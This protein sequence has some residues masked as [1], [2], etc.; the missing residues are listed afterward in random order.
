M[1]TIKVIEGISG[2][3]TDLM[4]RNLE[5][6]KK[7]QLTLTEAAMKRTA[8]SYG[9]KDWKA[10]LNMQREDFSI[11]KFREGSYAAA[12]RFST[13]EAQ[14][15]LAFGQLLR[16]GVQTTFN[17]IYQAVEVT[18]PAVV[19]EAGSNKRQEFY[20]PLERIGF[21]KKVAAQGSF[22]ETNFKGL[23]L[24]LVNSKY[25][26]IV[27]FEKELA[28]DD[29]TGQIVSRAGQMGENARIHEEA[30]V[31]ARLGNDT[32][33][34]LDGEALPVSATYGTVYSSAGIHTGG[35]GKNATAAGRLSATQIQNGWIL[36]KKMLDQSGRPMVVMPKIL[37]VSP[38][39]I[40]YAETLMNS[41][42]NP[43][44]ASTATGDDG[45]MFGNMTINPIKNLTAVVSTRFLHDY[46]ALLIDAGKGFVFQRR[47]P[48]EVVQEN[49]QSGPA[50]SQEV[51]RYKTRSRWEADFIDPKF[52]INLNTSFSST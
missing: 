28:D 31:W 52:I 23:D 37:A 45:K 19:R 51:F 39:D 48:Q 8:E 20:S 32:G 4:K 7:M 30:Y 18:Y 3:Q 9:I 6:S 25:G 33:A 11:K 34:S 35:Y 17:D 10:V 49:P 36:A 47:D 29:Q 21:P 42:L 46:A 43:S 24:E 2:D 41:E 15:E 27:A 14:A 26:M 22:P 16:A 50:F 1:K 38:Q 12:Q 13:Q 5:G 40:F 44:K